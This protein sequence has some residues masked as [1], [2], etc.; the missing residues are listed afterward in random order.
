MNHC[1]ICGKEITRKDLSDEDG[2][3]K[4]AVFHESFGVACLEH[5][6]V[7]ELYDALLEAA[8]TQPTE[9]FTAK[10]ESDGDA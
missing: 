6:G 2:T 9:K 3:P 7:P 4:T 8:K 5:S 1:K 10:E